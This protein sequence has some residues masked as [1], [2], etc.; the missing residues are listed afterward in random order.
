MKRQKLKLIKLNTLLL[1]LTIGIGMVHAQ[2]K[3]VR[4]IVTDESGLPLP[5]VTILIKGSSSGTATD[6]NGNYELTTDSKDVLVFSFMGFSSKEI[7]VGNKA[8]INVTLIENLSRLDEVV[9]VG[10]GSQKKKEVTG[11]VAKISAEEIMEAPV[12][13]V[14]ASLQGKV[15]GVN[16]Q[17]ASGRPGDASNIQIRGLVSLNGGEPLY[18]VDN[19]P[20][21]GNPNIAPEQIESIDILKDGASASIYGVRAAGGVILITTKKGKAGKMKVDISTYT[22][23]Q[24]ITS[25]PALSNTAGYLYNRETTAESAGGEPNTFFLDANALDW[26]TDFIEEVTSNNAQVQNVSANISGGAENLTFNFNTNYF[27]QDGVIKGS[28]FDRLTNRITGQYT[29]G[30]FKAFASISM[31]QENRNQEPFNFYQYG[32]GQAPHNRPFDE[33]VSQGNAVVL[34][35]DNEVFFSFLSRQLD[36]VDERENNNYSLALNLEY[37]IA[38]GL[39]Y[40]LNMGRNQFNFYRKFFQPQYLAIDRTGRLNESASRLNASLQ[41]FY[42]FATRETIENILNYKKSFGKHN[43]DLLAVISYEKFKNK[44]ISV[45]VLYDDIASNDVQVLSNGAEGIKPT[46]NDFKNTIAGK[47]ARVQYNY[48]GKYLFSASYRRDGSSRFPENNRYADF[49]GVSAG[50][51]VSDENWF[52]VEGISSLKLRGSMAETG[53]NNIGDYRFQQIIETGVNYPFGPNEDIVFGQVQRQYSNPDVAWETT[54]SKN[55]GVEIGLFNN[56]LNITADVYQNDKEDMLINQRLA[57]STGTWQPFAEG[58]YN[59]IPVNAG[60]MV[61]KGIELGINYRDQ[62]GDDFKYSISGVFSKNSNE[63]TELDGVTRGFANGFINVNVPTGEATTFLE[64]GR[65]AYAFFLFQND[66]VIKTAE[67]LVEYEMLDNSAG[68]IST[69]QLGDMRY[70]DTNGDGALTEDDRVYSGSGI[71]N[72]DVG[73][74]FN[75]DY[76]NW[77]LA[78]QMFYSNGAKIYNGGKNIAYTFGRHQ[79][80]VFQWTPQNPD[81]NI[82]TFRQTSGHSNI[83]PSSDYWLEDGTYLRVRTLSMGYTVPGMKNLGIEKLRVYINSLNPFTFTEYNGYDPEVGGNGISNRGIDF[84]NYPVS[85]QFMLGLQLSF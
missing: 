64:V 56:K 18:V 68:V 14:L 84:G 67:E 21:E 82:P 8:I 54:I 39:K 43:L 80:Q 60:N 58:S 66:G 62:I 81:S 31:T 74:N 12:S 34:D 35:V 20:Q 1:F 30:K 51:N 25:G 59:T 71:P 75:L 50:W 49:F 40:K 78:C 5:G 4:G 37:E 79:D 85:R 17:A 55:I 32:V 69:P 76:K 29:K 52:D 10:Y 9:V 15:A 57:P 27:K 48:D 45:G 65:E 6:F 70:K 26:D 63:V 13:D 38:E 46:G 44:N 23:I 77:D 28:D 47:L 24:N 83:K 22:G 11:A 19:I 16:V 42:N 41:E 36:N 72:F 7:T 61:N 33:I 73:L 2:S 53:F 3:S